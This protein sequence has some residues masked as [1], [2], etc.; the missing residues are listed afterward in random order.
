[1]SQVLFVHTVKISLLRRAMIH[2]DYAKNFVGPK[3]S[4][5]G[6]CR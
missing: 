6:D 2:C 4:G 1:M 3:L 5:T